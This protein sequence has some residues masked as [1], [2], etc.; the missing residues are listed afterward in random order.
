MIELG[1]VGLIFGGAFALGLIQRKRVRDWWNDERHFN[2]VRAVLVGL[3]LLVFAAF[4][5]V[6][7][8]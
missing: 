1:V 7:N 5:V 3:A 4:I 6:N 2:T 8:W